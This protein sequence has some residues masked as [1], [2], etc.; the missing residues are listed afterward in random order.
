MEMKFKVGERV[1]DEEGRK[2]TIS[3]VGGDGSCVQVR[4]DDGM[5]EMINT[6]TLRKLQTT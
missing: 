5:Q 4:L 3:R 1:V 2:G 6:A